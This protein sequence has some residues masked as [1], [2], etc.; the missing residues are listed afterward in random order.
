MGLVEVVTMS[1]GEKSWDS[2]RPSL[3]QAAKNREMFSCIVYEH[4]RVLNCLLRGQN[5]MDQIIILNTNS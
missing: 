1:S 3:E 2:L 5:H 4:G